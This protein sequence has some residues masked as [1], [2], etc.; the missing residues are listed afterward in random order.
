MTP[1]NK[2]I[3]IERE[4]KIKFYPG[5]D[6][7]EVL[8]ISQQRGEELNLAVKKIAEDNSEWELDAVIKYALENNTENSN[9][10][11]FILTEYLNHRSLKNGYMDDTISHIFMRSGARRY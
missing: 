11:L 6:L 9:E 2:L 8:G 4:L 10:E 3:L 1:T 5:H 7:L